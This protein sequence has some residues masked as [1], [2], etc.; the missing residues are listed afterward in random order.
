MIQKRLCEALYASG[1]TEEAA[2]AL[3]IMVSVV[4]EEVSMSA[5]ITTWVSGQL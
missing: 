2:E 1:R 4:D 3:L 5:P